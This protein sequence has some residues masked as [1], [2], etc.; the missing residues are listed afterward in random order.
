[1]RSQR[2]DEQALAILF[3]KWHQ[4]MVRQAYL[5]TGRQEVAQDIVQDCWMSIIK[6]I[7]GLRDPGSFRIWIFRIVRGKSVDWIRAM[8]RSRRHKESL[9]NETAADRTLVDNLGA[10]QDPVQVIR[11]AM[12]NLGGEQKY[13]LTLF[14]LQKTSIE[15]I[16]EILTIPVGTVKS[17][18]FHARKKLLTKIGI[19]KMHLIR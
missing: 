15:E 12:Q 11:R 17:R 19:S 1:M 5:L 8:Q 4:P 7:G 16:S 2:G 9:A 3:K 18:L 6:G 10:P 14:Y 13:L